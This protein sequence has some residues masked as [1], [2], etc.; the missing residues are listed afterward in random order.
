MQGSLCP[1]LRRCRK[2]RLNITIRI[3][4]YSKIFYRCKGIFYLL[5]QS[6]FALPTKRIKDSLF[7]STNM[8]I[9]NCWNQAKSKKSPFYQWNPSERGTCHLS[10][11]LENSTI[12]PS[13]GSFVECREV[14]TDKNR[15]FF[16]DADGKGTCYLLDGEDSQICTSPT[17]STYVLKE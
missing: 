13:L 17:G 4:K 2:N 3:S 15:T 5:D 7:V 10:R 9:A 14:A 1:N 11:P 12:L 16:W 8:S 6:W